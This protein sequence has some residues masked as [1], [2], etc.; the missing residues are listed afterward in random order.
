MSDFRHAV[1]ALC[2][3]PGFSTVAILTI[4]V[5]I[6]ANTS[7]FS[8]Y[9]RLVLNPVTIPNASSLVAIWTSNP[10]LNF[11]A[12]AVSWPRYEE[13]SDQARTFSSVGISAFDNF[14]LTGNGDPEQLNGLRVSATFFPTLGILPDVGRNFSASEDLPNGPSVCV[15]SHELWQTRFGGRPIVGDT[16]TLNSAPW[17][18]IGIMPPHLTPPFAQ[19]QVFAPRVFDVGGLTP[20]QVQNGAG[21]AQPI[22]RLKP[23]VTLD[24]ARDDLASIARASRER[25]PTRLDANNTMRPR[26]FV[27]ALVGNLRQT[28]N[29]LNGAV[30]FVLLIACANVAALFL[31]RLT[32]RHREI[33][34]RQSLGATRPHIIRQF[35]AE[36]FVFSLAAGLFG[37]L[38]ALWA[39][40]AVQSLVASQ[41]PPNTTLSLNT[42][43]LLFT[44]FTSVLTALLVGLVPAVQASRANAVEALKD[45]ARG[46]SSGRSGWFRSALIVGEVALSVVLLVGSSLLLASFVRLQRTAPGFEPDGVATAFVGVPAVRYPTPARQSQF[47]DDVIERLRAQ[48]GVSGAAAAVG[49]PLSGFNPRSPY[50]V[51]GRPVLPLPQRPLA[52]LDI[53]S[54]G[55]FSVMRIPLRAGRVFGASDTQT[56][57][58]VCAINESFAK[59][60]FPGESPLG[61]V[62]LRGRDANVRAEIVGVVGDV[63][64]T[65]LD[66]P[67]PDEIYYPLRQIAQAGT[68]VVR[69]QGL[70]ARAANGDAARLQ[71]AIRTAVASVDRDQAIS[72]FTTL[73][74]TIANS[75]GVQR[76]VASLTAVFAGIALILSAVGLYSVVAYAVSQRTSEIGIRMAL[77]AQRGQVIA[78]VMR[79]GIQLVAAGLVIGLAAA[80]G[81]SRLI[82]TLL[83]DVRPLEPAIYASVA[84][85]FAMV[86]AL[87]CLLP[88]LRASRI[89]PLIA[90][91]AV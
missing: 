74:N 48:P 44:A 20:L 66:I 62:L 63:K 40:S 83:F 27:E 6:G 37:V 64:S 32:A 58:G 88:S 57:P 86:A 18:V 84:A 11:N 30:A 61:H 75:L 65:G 33:A 8:V 35:T 67:A 71:S 22:A 54:D 39:L 76:I 31:G 17:Q 10:Q 79:G 47:F 50:S 81:T 13:I 53:V 59:R 21:Y 73:N 7:L 55:Y 51:G 85:V 80:A 69:V 34:V 78:L 25:F 49:I 60:L 41:L 43:A 16:I 77:G 9:D 89:D 29:A 1:R 23:G 12:P 68:S 19:A 45:S 70:L 52:N 24:Q 38:L 46:S 87:A 26:F 82:Q 3:S 5:G 91:R 4:A 90:L 28:F 72:A 42:R 36:S 15:I 56:S 14:T 2:K